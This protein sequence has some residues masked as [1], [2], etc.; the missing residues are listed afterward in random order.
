MKWICLIFICCLT[1]GAC[2]NDAARQ[3]IQA[4]QSALAESN[5]LIAS[6]TNAVYDQLTEHAADLTDH[7]AATWA[8]N[9]SLLHASSIDILSC[10]DSLQRSHVEDAF[11]RQTL[12]RRMA[13][14]RNTITALFWP[15]NATY[16]AHIPLPAIDQQ[17]KTPVSL[18][19]LRNEVLV[20]ENKLA[21]QCLRSI[22]YRDMRCDRFNPI[23][24]LT[25]SYVKKGQSI[26]V[27]IGMCYPDHFD[28]LKFFADGHPVPI[29]GND[30]M[31]E[32]EF[33]ATGA[34]G[35]HIVPVRIEYLKTDSTLGIIERN[36]E[37]EIAP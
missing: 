21:E 13:A 2:R 10:I 35:K 24:G 6:H 16:P 31:V 12:G 36:L 22:S 15:D 30:H 9:G 37:Y 20:T 14:Y 4:L 33:V 26:T 11:V 29:Q 25:S 1:A 7:R 28:G 34:P 23:A 19:Q 8:K 5:K 17:S 32:Y 18:E 3:D 27:V